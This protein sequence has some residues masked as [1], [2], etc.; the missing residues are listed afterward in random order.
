MMARFALIISLLA[1]G[2]WA[3]SPLRQER[4]MGFS[5]DGA[6][7]DSGGVQYFYQLVERDDARSSELV[8]RF[9]PLDVN[10]RWTALSEP[11]N[12]VVI[13]FVYTVDKDISFFTEA[14]AFDVDYINTVAKEMEVSRNSNGSFHIGRTP[15]NTC[16]LV[17]YDEARVRAASGQPA[18]KQ[19]L[20]L[21]GENGLPNSVVFQENTDFARVLG[22]RTA[23]ASMT[24][25]AHFPLAPGRT[26]V[27]VLTMSYLYELP[28]FFLGGSGRVMRESMRG[29]TDLIERLRAY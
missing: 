26:R 22:H 9:L 20:A 27:A 6:F 3:A 8:Q 12:V 28:P 21:T 24:W 29:A 4:D 14:R 17:H 1:G 5:I 10:D 15:E 13:R 7:Q 2:S 19:L 11:I 23:A 25:T 18:L 16:R